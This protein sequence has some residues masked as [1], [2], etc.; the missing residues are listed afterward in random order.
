MP[1]AGPSS[2][3][4]SERASWQAWRPPEADKPSRLRL[5]LDLN[6]SRLIEMPPDFLVSVRP[7]LDNQDNDTKL[8][9]LI[10]SDRRPRLKMRPARGLKHF[11]PT[12]SLEGFVFTSAHTSSARE[13]ARAGL[14]CCSLVMNESQLGVDYL[15]P[16]A[17]IKSTLGQK[18]Y[19]IVGAARES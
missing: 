12:Q 4:A 16:D 1:P 19:Y 11:C 14:H 18:Q 10:E 6:E 5:A 2:L 7:Q 3:R 15:A 9:G 17:I 8:I 13:F